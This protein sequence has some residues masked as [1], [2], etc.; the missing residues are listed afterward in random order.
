MTTTRH[1][2]AILIIDDD[3][4]LRNALR[5]VLQLRGFEVQLAKDAGEALELLDGGPPDLIILDIKMPG[6]DGLRLCR[7]IR[8]SHSM[9]I[10][11]LT[12]FDSVP[13]RVAGLE[14]GA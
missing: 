11:M 7:L 8:G 14:A 3:P 13:D 2:D 10:L 4:L 12:A 9:P 5:R 6:L 1:E